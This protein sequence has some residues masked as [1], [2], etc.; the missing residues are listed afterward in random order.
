MGK[1]T[2]KKTQRH[3]RRQ[4]Q[5]H[6]DVRFHR[7]Y[8][9]MGNPCLT[10]GEDTNN[11][12]GTCSECPHKTCKKGEHSKN[13]NIERVL[14]ILMKGQDKLKSASEE[15]DEKILKNKTLQENIKTLHKN[16][17]RRVTPRQIV[18]PGI[19][20]LVFHYK[21]EERFVSLLSNGIFRYKGLN[22]K[23]PTSCALHI[24]RNEF[25]P[26]LKTINGWDC[27]YTSKTHESLKKLRS[28]FLDKQEKYFLIA[29]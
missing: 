7:T 24:I 8:A 10:C 19:S 18:R 2:R 25:N 3:R 16:E 6:N 14:E 22:F 17:Q 1:T 11:T 13:V 26:E 20:A 5:R 27:F 15:N 28:E 23:T 12:C 9:G 4:R 21:D 29:K